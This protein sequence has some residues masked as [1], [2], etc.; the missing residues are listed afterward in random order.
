MLGWATAEAAGSWAESDGARGW[1]AGCWAG[2]AGA[3]ALSRPW[4]AFAGPRA[5][6]LDQAE[7]A[8]QKYSHSFLFSYFPENNLINLN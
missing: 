7:M 3:R 2:N 6:L 1:T 4:A 8:K 5:L